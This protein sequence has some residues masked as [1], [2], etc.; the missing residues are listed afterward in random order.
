[1]GAETLVPIPD[2]SVHIGQ[3]DGMSEID[4]IRL[5]RLY[6]CYGYSM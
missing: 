3:R 2:S 4:V 1:M 6:K 5:N